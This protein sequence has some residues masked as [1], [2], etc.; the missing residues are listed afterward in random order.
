MKNKIICLV[1]S[2]VFLAGVFGF[3]GTYA[4]FTTYGSGGADGVLHNFKTGNIGYTLVGS[5][6]SE[7]ISSEDGE[8]VLIQPEVELL[9]ELEGNYKYTD[10]PENLKMYLSNTSLVNTQLRFKVTYTY[11]DFDAKQTKDFVYD[12]AE[13]SPF[14][15]GLA[16]GWQ[17]VAQ[18]SNPEQSE[19]GRVGG[20]FYYGNENEFIPSVTEGTQYLPLFTSLRYSGENSDFRANLYDNTTTFKVTVTFQ[21]KQADYVNWATIGEVGFEAAPYVEP[22]TTQ[23]QAS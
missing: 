3:G 15:V 11:F 23:A 18:D 17:F 13:D 4:W 8:K 19:E 21:A 22:T 20:Y 12:G 6:D 7:L 2:V 1:L 9:A 16:D 10:M 14:V 5:F